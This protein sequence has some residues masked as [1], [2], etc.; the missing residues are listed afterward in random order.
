M[1]VKVQWALR[2]GAK[3]CLRISPVSGVCHG[4]VLQ[5]PPRCIVREATSE[6]WFGSSASKRADPD[7]KQ[8]RLRL[9]HKLYYD[10]HLVTVQI[11]PGVE[12]LQTRLLVLFSIDRNKS[13]A[14]KVVR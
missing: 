14:S 13:F 3:I 1:S 2:E 5:T 9:R 10:S 4:R 7:P 6:I 11:S 8:L 12:V